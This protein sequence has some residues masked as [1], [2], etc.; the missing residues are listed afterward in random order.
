MLEG[1]LSKLPLAAL[2]ASSL[3]WLGCESQHVDGRDLRGLFAPTASVPALS[4]PAAVASTPAKKGTPVHKGGKMAAEVLP[5]LPPATE[6]E[7]ITGPCVA[8]AGEPVKA[9]ERKQGRPACRGSN[10]LEHQGKDATPRYACLFT[11]GQF[12]KRKPLPLVVFL[13]GELDDPTAVHKKTR[14]RA[15]YG[16]LDLSGDPKRPGFAI[17]APQARRV[18]YLLRWDVEHRSRDNL[19]AVAINRFVEELVA[20]GSVDARQ[21]YVIGDSRGGEMA[22]LFAHLYPERVAGFGAFGAA[23]SSLSWT[24]A[25]PQPPAAVVYRAC[26]AVTSCA[27]VERWLSVRDRERAPTFSLRLG[28]GKA[29]EPSCALDKSKCGKKKGAANHNRWPEPREQELLEYLS[30]FSFGS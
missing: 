18:K 24:C 23:P 10:V 2:M 29:T 16:K 21:I 3:S 20:A 30:R 9:S 28:D 26:D 5:P 11:D 27:D 15:R 7:R 8:P 22:A 17:L 19:D 12:E 25:G 1:A 6:R 13:H 14:L 4:Q